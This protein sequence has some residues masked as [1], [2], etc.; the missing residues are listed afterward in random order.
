MAIGK[1][2][3]P[4]KQNKILL[5]FG[6]ITVIEKGELKI[7]YDEKKLSKYLKS[8]E[9]AINV[10]LSL[11]N[12]TCKVWTCDFTKDYISINADYRS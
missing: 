9:I 5:Q 8:K 10:D 4:I 3:A 1:A 11:G 7:T 2:K 6:D 12:S